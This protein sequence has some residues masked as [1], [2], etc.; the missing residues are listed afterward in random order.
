MTYPNEAGWKKRDTS[1][2]AAQEINSKAATIR[3]KVYR[4]LKLGDYT[5]DEVA[6]LIYEPFSNVRPRCS[7]LADAQLIFDSGFR[8]KNA[9]NKSVIVWTVT[10]PKNSTFNDHGA[11]I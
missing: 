5:A 4:T 3:N 2:E 1:R 10:P 9:N 6:A 7:E 8:K 11:A